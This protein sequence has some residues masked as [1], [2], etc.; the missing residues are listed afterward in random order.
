MRLIIIDFVFFLNF[1]SLSCWGF[2]VL[3]RRSSRSRSGWSMG[4]VEEGSIHNI[5]RLQAS[6]ACFV[7]HEL[8]ILF[9]VFGQDAYV[10]TSRG[11]GQS[12]VQLPVS[13]DWLV[14]VDADSFAECLALAFVD[15]H[16][17]RISNRELIAA[18]CDREVCIP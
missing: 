4:S 11:S 17:P 12:A 15:G 14:Q 13:K 18:H 10:L 7:G 8:L 5:Q 2:F 3:R 6:V 9:E 1:A 16:G